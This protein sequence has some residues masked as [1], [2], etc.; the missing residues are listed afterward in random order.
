[1]IVAN[2]GKNDGLKRKL[3]E[4][5]RNRLFVAIDE[6]VLKYYSQTGR[7]TD[8]AWGEVLGQEEGRP[9][10]HG[11]NERGGGGK[12]TSLHNSLY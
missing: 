2:D 9:R 7:L 11:K 1:M 3:A 4:S 5:V 6:E 12:I 8:S 10:P